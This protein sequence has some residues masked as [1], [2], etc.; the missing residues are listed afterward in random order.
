MFCSV[1][2]AAI[3]GVDAVKV[4]VEADVSDGMPQFVMVG[5]VSTQVK[6]GQD[7]VKT[8]LRNVGVVL[9]PKRVTINLV[10]ADIRKDG[11]RFDLPV[12]VAFLRSIGRIPPK[13]LDD[14]MVIGEVRL[15]GGIQGVTGVLS[16]VLLARELGCRRCVIPGDNI[17]EGKIVDGIQVIGV[18]SIEQLIQYCCDEGTLGED[19]EVNVEAE[20]DYDVDFQDILGQEYVKRAALIAAC[21]FHNLLLRGGPGSGK[22]M[23]AK[24][25]P[26][27][28]P[29]LTKEESLELSKIYSVA[30][31]LPEGT[32][33]LRRRPFR[34]PHHTISPQA[35]AGGGRIPVPGEITLAHHGVLFLDEMA[36]ASRQ[37]IEI[38]RQPL[39]ERQ[40]V[41]SR[42][43]GRFLFPANFMLVGAINSCPCGYYPDL[44]RCTCTMQEMIRYLNKIS[45]PLLDRMDLCVEVPA[46]SYE[47]LTGE[48]RQGASSRELRQI[49]SRVHH[50]QRE[51]Y[52][53][54][55]KG[56]NV[57]VR[58]NSE[59]SPREIEEFCPVTRDGQKL[60]KQAFQTYGMT[61]RG[62]HKII[63]VARTI[64]D[65][66]GSDVIH[67]EHI[68][69]AICYRSL[70]KNIWKRI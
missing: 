42:T 20:E 30:G 60:L 55:A 54:G 56:E 24:R 29:E 40:I 23:L 45:L 22:S 66:E 7:R 52:R 47:D 8:A 41:I 35:L 61:A 62:Y 19:T 31:L 64:A 43:G 17:I 57:T 2:S 68:S 21:G 59:L 44:N 53:E 50:L 37:T 25:I 11:S 63:K 39:E 4:Q 10:P 27:I 13:A 33:I 67:T 69:E 14:A 1:L 16:T 51:R 12:A 32:P 6:E 5:S 48:G 18:E 38:L 15:N 3:Y 28:M 49:V 26:S 70:D 9:P 36:E 34:Q 65:M 58:Y 46:L